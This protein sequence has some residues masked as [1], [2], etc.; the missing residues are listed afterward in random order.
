LPRNNVRKIVEKTA[1][2][3]GSKAYRSARP[4]SWYS[5][6]ITIALIG[7]AGIYYSR[8]ELQHPVAQKKP[9]VVQPAVGTRWTEAL[10][11]YICSRFEPNLAPSPNAGV[12]GLTSSGSGLINIDPKNS[13]E[14]GNNATLGKFVSEYPGLTLTANEISLPGGIHFKNG[15]K[16]P[17]QKSP[18]YIYIKVFNSTS[19]T[20]GHFVS[21]DPNKVKLTNGALITVAF[22]PRGVALNRPPSYLALERALALQNTTSS[23]VPAPINS[24]NP[25]ISIPQ[26]STSSKP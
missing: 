2:A 12:V 20:K 17:S 7:F 22:V 26:N 14:S 24:L 19:D 10:G 21:S 16:C 6:L 18:G 5:L 13:S 4:W 25:T 23:Q 1:A 3:G 9:K 15:Q 11:F 8:Y